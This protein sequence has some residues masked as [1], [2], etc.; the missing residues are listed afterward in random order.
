MTDRECDRCFEQGNGRC[1]ESCCGGGPDPVPIRGMSP[2][3]RWTETEDRYLYD[4][5]GWNEYSMAYLKDL[6]PHRSER[7]I[8]ARAKRLGF[9]GRERVDL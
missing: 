7:A 6:L 5:Y 3:S 8:R 4:Q 9:T 1:N 2:K